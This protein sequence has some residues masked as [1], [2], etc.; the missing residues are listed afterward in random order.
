MEGGSEWYRAAAVTQQT[1][2]TDAHNTGK[3]MKHQNQS[4]LESNM[5]QNETW[6]WQKPLEQCSELDTI[7]DESARFHAWLTITIYLET[8]PMNSSESTHLCFKMKWSWP[9]N[10]ESLIDIEDF[11]GRSVRRSCLASKSVHKQQMLKD[12]VTIQVLSPISKDLDLEWLYSALP[13]P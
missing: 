7:S 8:I 9:T 11:P 3:S 10:M 6:S 4:C 5:I 2:L 1:T 12:F 13:P